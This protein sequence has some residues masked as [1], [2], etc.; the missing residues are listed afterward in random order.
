MTVPHHMRHLLRQL[1]RLRA[2]R[3]L[4]IHTHRILSPA[5]TRKRPALRILADQVVDLS[6]DLLRLREAALGVLGLEDMAIA[7][8]DA[9]EPVRVVGVGREPVV[10]APGLVRQDGLDQ[11]QIREGVADGLVDQLRQRRQRRERVSLRGRL[12]FVRC[13]GLERGGREEHGAV[14]VGFEIDADIEA[15]SGVVEVLDPRWRALDG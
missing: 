6:L 5:R 9:H 10:R 1:I 12:R 2:R 7:D 14:A 11:E 4:G 8:L 13:D 15:L 3:R